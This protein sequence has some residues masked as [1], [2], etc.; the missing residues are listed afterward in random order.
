MKA[1]SYIAKAEMRGRE[2]LTGKLKISVELYRNKKPDCKGYGDGDNHL[3]AIFDALNGI[4][5]ADDS[6]IVEGTFKKF[7]DKNPHLII[8]VGEVRETGKEGNS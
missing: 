1:L 3:K 4:V 2:P 8:E 6:Q 5:F 7:K